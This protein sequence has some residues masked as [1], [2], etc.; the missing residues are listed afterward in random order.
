MQ[1][2]DSCEK[3]AE[4]RKSE[5]ASPAFQ[6]ELLPMEEIYR[7]AGIMN[8]QKG[9]SIH[10]VVRNAEQ[11][12]YSG[13]SNE[14]KRAAV[15]VA[16]EAAGHF[17]RS[18][19]A[20]REGAAGGSGIDTR[21]SRRS[22]SKRNGRGRR[23]KISGFKRNLERVKGQLYGAG[24]PQSGEAAR[25]KSKFERWLAMKQQEDAEA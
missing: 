5:D 18:G 20:G 10:K 6:V 14:T 9:Y 22:R 11:R 12:T 2:A 21:R 23:K 7:A 4:D 16:L 17:A 13:L 3:E 19:A 24:E 1:Q 15:M 25:E 8:S